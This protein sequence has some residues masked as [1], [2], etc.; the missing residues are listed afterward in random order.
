MLC[1]RGNASAC[2]ISPVRPFWTNAATPPF[3]PVMVQGAVFANI[4]ITEGWDR[5][6]AEVIRTGDWVRVDP[7][8][9]VIELLRPA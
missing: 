2:R 6:P 5:P 7:G 4:T 8:R 9:R 3:N 1:T